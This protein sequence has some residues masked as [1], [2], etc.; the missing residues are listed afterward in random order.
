[1]PFS[2]SGTNLPNH[3]HDQTVTQD[4]GALDFDNAT[5]GSMA[6]GSITYDDGVGHMQE[7][8]IGTPAQVLTVS[9]TNLPS[10][11]AT[12][13]AAAVLTTQGQILYHDGVGLA[14]LNAGVSGQVLQTAGAGANPT[15]A[16]PS[17]AWNRIANVTQTS[18]SSTFSISGLSST[19]LF[20][21]FQGAFSVSASDEIRMRLGTG[22]VVSTGAGYSWERTDN[23]GVTQTSAATTSIVFQNSTSAN[24]TYISGT[25]MLDAGNAGSGPN[26]TRAGTMLSRRSSEQSFTTWQW[27]N[28]LPN[29]PLTDIQFYT[30]SGNDLNGTV[31]IWASE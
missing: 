31:N 2:E 1:M 15:W 13:G 24:W 3:K 28:G 26:G 29:S 8:G 12:G 20:L 11:A 21:E 19:G 9:G 18:G 27:N 5:S 6:A 25:M 4:G 22:N 14:A 23:S 30:N 16:A 10:W 7:L 17:G